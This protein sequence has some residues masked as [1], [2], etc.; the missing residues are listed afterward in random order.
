MPRMLNRGIMSPDFAY[1]VCSFMERTTCTRVSGSLSLRSSTGT[2]FTVGRLRGELSSIESRARAPLTYVPSILCSRTTPK[3]PSKTSNRARASRPTVRHRP[4]AECANRTPL[5]SLTPGTLDRKGLP[6]CIT[7][8]SDRVISSAAR[9]P[10]R[11]SCRLSDFVC[12]PQRREDTDCHAEYMPPSTPATVAPEDTSAG[13]DV[14]YSRQVSS[15]SC[16]DL[17]TAKNNSPRKLVA[18]ARPLQSNTSPSD[19][20]MARSGL[21]DPLPLKA[22]LPTSSDARPPSPRASASSTAPTGCEQW[23]DSK[24][25][26]VPGGTSTVCTQASLTG[27]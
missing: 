18:E 9:P 10:R 1:V 12:C 19:S 11:C 16:P 26:M 2:R 21:W 8:P 24:A 5:T 25:A 27:R 14:T 15:P 7:S 23:S 3:R 4:A 6:S 20:R 13:R 17:V 22:T